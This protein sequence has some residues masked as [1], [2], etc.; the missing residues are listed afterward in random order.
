MKYIILALL[1]SLGVQLS[2][3]EVYTSSGKSKYKKKKTEGY[4]PEKLIVGGGFNVN[5]G[6]GY[7]NLGVSPSV[8][9][10]FTKRFSA[11]VVV[12]YQYFRFPQNIYDY[13]NP[14]KIFY[15]KEHIVYPGVWSRFFVFNNV[16]LSAGFEYNF[17]NL[18]A[19]DYY[20]DNFGNQIISEGKANVTVPALPVGIGIRQPVGGR[21]SILAELMYDALQQQYSPYY[22]QPFL[23]IS[24]LAGM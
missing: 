7:L 3:Q 1:L 13:T 19:Y 23:R 24:V 6:N 4:D 18:K 15:A 12:G 5:F 20:Y 8:G 11:G 14:N 10:R 17:I 2:A 21:V 22:G 16:F 9:Y